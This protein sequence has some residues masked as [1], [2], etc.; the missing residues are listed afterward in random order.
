MEHNNEIYL[1]SWETH[2]NDPT[3]RYKIK[4][5]NIKLIGKQDN[6]TTLIINSEEIAKLIKRP[7]EHISKYISHGLSCPIKKEKEYDCLGFKGKYTIDI[8]TKY[9]M[10]YIKIYVLCPICD[11]PETTLFIQKDKDKPRGLSHNCNACGK[12]SLV[13]VNS[14]DKTYEYIEKNTK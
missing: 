1:A 5:L 11:L 8:I 9:F 2:L 6:W 12:I 13:R 10:D 14:I 3:Y 4:S 7:I